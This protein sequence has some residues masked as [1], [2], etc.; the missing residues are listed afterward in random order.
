MGNT[1][2]VLPS[3]ARVAVKDDFSVTLGESTVIPDRTGFAMYPCFPDAHISIHRHRL[4]PSRY[5]ITLAPF[6]TTCPNR[7]CGHA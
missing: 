7:E 4:Q 2:A 1:V 6:D 5:S 3:M